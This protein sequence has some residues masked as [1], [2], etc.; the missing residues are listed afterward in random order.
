LSWLADGVA[1]GWSYSGDAS[2]PSFITKGGAHE[3][4][5]ACDGHPTISP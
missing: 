4:H 3:E 5:H 2:S 1:S